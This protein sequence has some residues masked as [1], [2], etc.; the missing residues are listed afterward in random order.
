MLVRGGICLEM[1]LTEFVNL[2]HCMSRRMVMQR[3]G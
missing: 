3:G 1:E 2:V